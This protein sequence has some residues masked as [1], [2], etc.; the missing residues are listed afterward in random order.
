MTRYS[1]RPS[2]ST[3]SQ[4]TATPLL[5]QAS[6]HLFQ[7]LAPALALLL[8]GPI[9]FAPMGCEGINRHHD[10]RVVDIT[11][12]ADEDLGPTPIRRV[13]L[14]ST[15]DQ[16]ETMLAARERY[17]NEMI[18]TERAYLQ[19]GDTEKA[20]WARRQ[21]AQTEGVEV[22]P[23]L[24]EGATEQHHTVAPKESIAKADEIYLDAMKLYDSFEGVPFV[25]FTKINHEDCRTA[26]NMYKRILKD[27]P[28]SDKVDDAAYYA[29]V[30]YKEFL[31]EDDPDNELA[32]RYFKWALRLDPK[33]PHP[34]RFDAAVVYDFRLHDRERAIEMYHQVLEAEEA[35]IES[36]QRFAATRIEQLTDDDTSHLRPRD[37]RYAGRNRPVA[38][39]R[40]D[41]VE[42]NTYE[43]RN[44]DAL[45]IGYEERVED[46]GYV[47]NS[48]NDSSS[49]R[50]ITNSGDAAD[51]THYIT[52]TGNAADDPR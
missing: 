40:N 45:D 18:A 9:F 34:A 21:R 2:R 37:A 24:R 47:T 4:S 32:L 31:R 41:R 12:P 8:C 51:D 10:S 42:R 26:V 1:I 5:A 35:G 30:I 3:V 50:Y 48:G 46:T 27:Y 39:V 33:T 14:P 17:I 38:P 44:G 11:P 16:V 19:I 23:Y 29:G 36:N 6:S 28:T 52:N 7:R 13:S 49:T 20:N 15:A 43:P 25:G 22:Y